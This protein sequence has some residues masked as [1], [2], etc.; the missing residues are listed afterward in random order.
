MSH[1]QGKWNIDPGGVNGVLKVLHGVAGG[2]TGEATSYATHLQQAAEHAGR[3]SSEDAPTGLVG[4]SLANFGMATEEA[5]KFI[6]TRTG[7]S[8]N[9]AQDAADW[10]LSGDE[11]MADTT[12]RDATE[13]TQIPAYRL[14]LQ[15]KK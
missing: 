8:I 5:L 1:A 7:K 14:P 13:G 15:G 4:V 10:Y 3:L 11:Q 2:L 6:F 9:G 12:L